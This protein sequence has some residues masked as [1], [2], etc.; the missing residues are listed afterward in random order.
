MTSEPNVWGS[1][2][3]HKS[4]SFKK[5]MKRNHNPKPDGL[6]GSARAWS[7][8]RNVTAHGAVPHSDARTS[9]CDIC[10]FVYWDDKR[11]P[12]GSNFK[13]YFVLSLKFLFKT[14]FISTLF[15]QK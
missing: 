6:S 1:R 2:S 11:D 8:A 15:Q 12:E 5:K 3:T 9:Q 13:K 7:A 14:L 4:C 10:D